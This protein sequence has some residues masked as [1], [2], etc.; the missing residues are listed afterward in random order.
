MQGEEVNSIGGLAFNNF[1]QFFDFHPE[2]LTVFSTGFGHGLVKGERTQW[3][4]SGGKGL[5]PHGIYVPAY[6][7]VHDGVGS[8][9]HCSFDFGHFV[10]YWFF[11]FPI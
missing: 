11:L 4:W 9:F 10:S 3:G 6:T 8:R 5:P 2:G 1:K 7:E